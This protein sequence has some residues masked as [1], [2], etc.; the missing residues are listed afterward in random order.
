M[1]NIAPSE[2]AGDTPDGKTLRLFWINSNVVPG[3]LPR[4]GWELILDLFYVGVFLG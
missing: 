2:N 1:H 3:H 4:A